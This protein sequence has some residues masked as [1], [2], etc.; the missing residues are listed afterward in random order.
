M[1]GLTKS[2]LAVLVIIALSLGAVLVDGSRQRAKTSEIDRLTF[3]DLPGPALAV[4]YFESRWRL[5]NENACILY[6]G[7]RSLST[8]DFVYAQ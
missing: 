6:P 7:M 5:L 1:T 4:P 3:C 2:Y 8:M